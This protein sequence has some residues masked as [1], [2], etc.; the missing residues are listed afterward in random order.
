MKITWSDVQQ[1]RLKELDAAPEEQNTQF[2][3]TV[4]R[5]KTFQKL[6]KRLIKQARYRL[7]EFRE[8]FLRPALCRLET[9]L[10]EALIAKG[11]VQVT[12]PVIMS[13]G[14]LAKMTI[15]ENHPLFSQVYWLDKDKCLRPMLAPHLYYVL[16]DL[17][18]LWEKPVRI[19]EVG[20]CFRK[21][22]QGSQHSTEFTMLNLVEMGLLQEHRQERLKEL[23]ALVIKTSGLESF[24]LETENSTVYGQTI[25]II[26]GKDNF[27]VGSAAMGP[28]ELDKA[29]RITDAWVGI[30]FG[31]ERLLM[32]KENSQNL[33]K[34]GRSLA[35][36]N[37]IRLNV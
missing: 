10:V 21:E 2:E 36:L 4:E 11:F 13:R 33:A 24:N 30:G 20:P 32:A 27:E 15:E 34:V 6:E 19:F 7:K 3:N 14:L 8:K 18:R 5:D 1:R 12:T 22:S 23:A 28:H 37:G 17:L 35:Y 31:L 26:A 16:K 25:D 9:A 29:W